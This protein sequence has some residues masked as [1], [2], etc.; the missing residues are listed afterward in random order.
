MRR[1]FITLS[2]L[3]VNAL[4]KQRSK[5]LIQLL[6]VP[7]IKPLVRPFSSINSNN[8]P[9][10]RTMPPIGLGLSVQ[11]TKLIN[12]TIETNRAVIFGEPASDEVSKVIMLFL[13]FVLMK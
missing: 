5:R 7:L 2:P 4:V 13:V 10:V 9:P 3:L 12:E 6:G 8:N 1:A 11:Y